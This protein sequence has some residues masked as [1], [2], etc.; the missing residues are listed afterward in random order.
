MAADTTETIRLIACPACKSPVIAALTYSVK[1]NPPVY[2][3]GDSVGPIDKTA[4]AT[5]TLIGV[6]ISHECPPPKPRNP[7][8]SGDLTIDIGNPVTRED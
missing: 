3:E 2:A 4:T 5:L 6:R 7:F 1:L 8:T